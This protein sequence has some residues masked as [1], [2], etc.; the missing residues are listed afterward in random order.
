GANA[1]D[2][3]HHRARRRGAAPAPPCPRGGGLPVQAVQRYR[4]AG[5]AHSRAGMRVVMPMVARGAEADGLYTGRQPTSVRHIGVALMADV[6]AVVFV[7]DDDVSVRESLE[8][9][10]EHAGWRAETFA[11]A[12]EFLARP[13]ATVPCCLV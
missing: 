8:L 9:L 3:L 4:A 7:V 12:G 1:S 13:R 5:C 11:S 2:C 6:T 10:I